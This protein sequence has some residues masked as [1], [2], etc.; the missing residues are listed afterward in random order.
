[1]FLILI[2]SGPVDFG[3]GDIFSIL[4]ASD[5]VDSTKMQ[6]FLDL[7]LP[8]AI[9][10]FLA[11]ASLSVCGLLMQT[12]FQ[13]PLAGPFVLG[14]HSGSALGVAF[15]I[16]GASFFNIIGLPFVM[17][18]GIPLAAIGGGTLVLMFLLFLSNK[19]PGKIVILVIGLLFGHLSAGII[20]ILVA[21]SD[22]Q[23]IKSF[24]MWSLGSFSRMTNTDLPLFSTVTIVGMIISSFYVK[25]LN[26]LLLGDR[27]AKTMGVNLKKIKI[28]LILLS[29]T[30]SGIVSAYCGPI[31][32]VGIIVP[33]II[34]KLMKT[35]DHKVLFPAVVLGGGVL[36]M[37][38][39]MIATINESFYLP[40]NAIFGLMGAPII[41]LFIWNKRKSEV[42]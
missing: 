32:F 12:F 42:L 34:K 31:A 35:S 10:A 4:F 28:I 13:N 15:L 36:A 7:R 18:M 5:E 19:I 40:L 16:M 1:M 14:V 2:Q 30:L 41:F 3:L 38:S 27:Y 26:V 8:K 11:G 39:E 33:H 9:T 6:I 23:E 22:S 17:T 21:V 20:N 25:H 37:F 29:G 24:L